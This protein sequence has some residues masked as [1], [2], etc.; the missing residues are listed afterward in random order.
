MKMNSLLKIDLRILRDPSARRL[1]IKAPL[2]VAQGKR[3]QPTGFPDLGA[4][5]YQFGDQENLLV[6]SPQSMA[7]RLEMTIWNSGAQEPIDCVKGISYV[8]VLRDGKYLTSTIEEAH[9]INSPYILEGEDKSFYETLKKEL[10][11]LSEGPIDRAL[12]ATTLFKYDVNSL[13]HG[14]FLA[15]KPLAGGRLRVSRAVSAFIEAEQIVAALSGGV[16]ND[17]VNPAGD[18][19]SGFGNVPFSRQEFVAP[20]IA[21]YFSIDLAQLRGYGLGDDAFD[22]LTLLVLL[23]IRLFLDGD[24]RLRTACE[25]VVGDE[26]D[27]SGVEGFSLPSRKE[28]EEAMAGAINKVKGK[29]AGENGV[30]E[31][32]YSSKKKQ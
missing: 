31:V 13:L 5:R 30:T 23:K 26:I 22:L 6:E 2:E 21:A 14:V 25:F 7:N 28:L 24:M 29:F 16:K 12:L 1:R 17:H 15:K 11:T 20:T 8:R 19:S 9:R 4:A 3:F 32:T 27:V 18:T 10:G